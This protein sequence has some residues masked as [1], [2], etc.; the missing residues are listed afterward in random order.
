MNTIQKDQVSLDITTK[1]IEGND[2]SLSTLKGKKVLLSFFRFST[3]PFC[4]LRLHTLAKEYEHLNVE[5]IAIF[6]SSDDNLQK[7]LPHYEVP[8]III[9]DKQRRFY[10]EYGVDRSLI[11]MLKGIFT[12]PIEM[13]RGMMLSGVPFIVD[14][15]VT[16]MPADF[17][18]DE[19]G[20]IRD[21]YY[22]KDEGDHMPL[23][24]IKRFTE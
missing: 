6:E 22:G 2:F 9:S 14:G 21:V 23:E 3:C 5:I 4:N 10:R 16:Q 11:G 7:H 18:I 15:N 1:D 12:R 17:L 19:N 24:T 20:I 8:F 13:M